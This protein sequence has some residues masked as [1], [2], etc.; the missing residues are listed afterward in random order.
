MRMSK[1][2]FAAVVFGLAAVLFTLLPPACA[3]S[4]QMFDLGSTL[5]YSEI[6]GIN[7]S[8]DVVLQLL[9]SPICASISTYCYAISS[10]GTITS[11]SAEVP[12]LDYDN[13]GTCNH[14]PIYLGFPIYLC[15]NGRVAIAGKT[16]GYGLWVG[17]DPVDGPASFS[18]L[19]RIFNSPVSRLRMNGSGDIAFS[20]G[21]E[22]FEAYD[23]TGH[24][25]PEPR[26]LA[27]FATGALGAAGILRRRS[28][29]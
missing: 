2:R 4:Y 18:E 15:N 12:V 9:G 19:T 8:G 5:P 20:T 6:Y 24:G 16:F 27:L 7:T 3:D 10:Q 22:N 1:L 29:G 13:A 26:T 23:L 28:V 17:P 25:V 11:Y 21:Y 14:Q